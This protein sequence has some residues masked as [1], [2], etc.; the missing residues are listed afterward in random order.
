M[1]KTQVYSWRM[2]PVTK[3]VLENEARRE[4]TTVAALLER[5]TKEW[6]SSK[7]DSLD[8]ETEQARLHAAA[9]RTIGTIAGKDSRRA[10]KAGVSVRRRIVRQHGR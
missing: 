1:N 4:R 8:D 7:R 6:V 5:I 9:R 2:T 3:A 10:E